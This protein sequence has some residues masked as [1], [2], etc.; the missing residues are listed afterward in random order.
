MRTIAEPMLNEFREETNITRRILARVPADKLM[1]KPHPKSM[2]LGQ[3]AI[4]I[5]MVP[6][7]LAVLATQSDS[8]DVAQANFLPDQPKDLKEIHSTFE[9]NVKQGESCLK[10]E[11]LAIDHA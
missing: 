11:R 1:W 10:G 8:F 5:A 6:G 4:H 9:D 3:L 2:T 7:R